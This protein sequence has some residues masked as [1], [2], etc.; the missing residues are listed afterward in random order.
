MKQ[1]SIL[2]VGGPDSGKSNFIGRAW[3]A[4][5]SGQHS[6]VAT[7]MPE[8]IEYVLETA[9]H[10][11]NGNFAPRTEHSEAARNVM[12]EVRAAEGSESARIVIPDI[13]GEL[14]KTAVETCE[15]E[16]E[17]M[18]VLEEADGA[19]LF[20]R[21]GSTENVAPLDWVTSGALLAK[22]TRP[23]TQGMPTQVMLCELLRFMEQKL[24]C[25]R[26]GT[27]PRV[28]LIVAAWDKLDEATRIKG[29]EA[30]LAKE[31]PLLSGKLSDSPLNVKVFGLSIVGG[32]L[33]DDPSYRASYLQGSVN[34][35]GWVMTK[36]DV[37]DE[38]C[39]NPDLTLPIGWVVGL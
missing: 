10:I 12:I 34:E 4:L 21:C 1:R 39:A 31:Y 7:G 33:Q 24:A 36:A 25:R 17:W 6:L 13:K 26:D 18:D 19:I 11:C 16:A 2:V 20:V 23:A 22:R 27:A 29:P 8:N 9:E 35:H 32:D 37:G 3:L 14:W 38:W 15:I 28:S 5:D 30:Y